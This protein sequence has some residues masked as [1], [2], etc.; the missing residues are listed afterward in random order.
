MGYLFKFPLIFN[1]S[2]LLGQTFKWLPAYGVNGIGANGA[3]LTGSTLDQNV[4]GFINKHTGLFAWNTLDTPTAEG[5]Y[6]TDVTQ[7]LTISSD[8]NNA[9]WTKIRCA[10]PAVD[11]IGP[12]GVTVDANTLTEDGSASTTHLMSR[13][14]ALV[15]GQYYTF[16]IFVKA[17]TRQGI[18]MG[19][20]GNL[21][22][23]TIIFNASTGKVAPSGTAE[24]M[25]VRKVGTSGW[26]K[27]GFRCLATGTGNTTLSIDM[28]NGTTATYSGDG[29]STVFVAKPQVTNTKSFQT[30]IADAGTLA[31]TDHRLANAANAYMGA[32]GSLVL[33][34]R[35][36]RTAAA[37][38]ASKYLFDASV[39]ANNLFCL[40][41]DATSKSY[42]LQIS[43]SG[44]SQV[45]LSG[46]YNYPNAQSLDIIVITWKTNEVTMYING[47]QVDQATVCT[48]PV[49]NTTIYLG[50]SLIPVS[51]NSADGQIQYLALSSV[52]WSSVDALVGDQ[53][54]RIELGAESPDLLFYAPLETSMA[55]QYCSIEVLRPATETVDALGTYLDPTLQK[56]VQATANAGRLQ[57]KGLL[58]E[59]TGAN[60][61]WQSGDLSVSPWVADANVVVTDHT[62]TVPPPMTVAGAKTWKLTNDGLAAGKAVKQDLVLRLTAAAGSA[63]VLVAS[64]AS[65]SP[66]FTLGIYDDTATAYRAK[67]DFTWTAGV[68]AAGTPTNGT[69][70]AEFLCT[71]AGVNYYWATIKAVSGITAANN[72]G[73]H[74]LPT[75]TGSTAGY[76]LACAVDITVTPFRTS[77]VPTAGA[78]V[79]DA[80][81]AIS[82]S[83]LNNEL[84][85]G[86]E[87]TMILAYTPLFGASEAVG[88][89]IIATLGNS[90]AAGVVYLSVTAG[91]Y[92]ATIS[93]TGNAGAAAS[94]VVPV[95]GTTVILA[96]TWKLN[97][98]RMF[99][100]GVQRAQDTL[101]D[102][103][104]L[105]GNLVLGNSGWSVATVNAANGRVKHAKVFKRALTPTQ[106]AAE[107]R[108]IKTAMGLI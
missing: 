7:M 66:T 49:P 41:Y 108:L 90:L 103:P 106:I 86:V 37:M 107:T 2:T 99:T 18:S 47:I 59:L 91:L 54:A 38:A 52:C 17:G 46:T 81:D 26:Y 39:D 13:A 70:D 94:A 29:V 96:C 4:R 98:L 6:E 1:L 14:V 32:T 33:T 67:C 23:F 24:K 12:D 62:A 76:Q 102:I 48:I 95:K 19:V 71:I 64:D 34:Y 101:V 50:N 5:H 40:T 25:W 16:S 35:P 61:C 30:Y 97:D 53:L 56:I 80:F 89:N 22:A 104:V 92:R 44:V 78:S 9:Y 57:S 8:F 3:A 82:F 42:R 68:L 84:G 60:I 45:N 21:S 43:D 15:S 85:Y 28:Y 58:I 63:A 79:S 73:F 10:T 88:N 36:N 74:F 75:G 11:A 87:G 31:F 20:S 51:A 77:Y 83:N 100:D 27:I 65:A 69:A 72:H 93:L 55:P 105:S